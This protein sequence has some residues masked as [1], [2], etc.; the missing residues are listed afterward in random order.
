M[1]DID[2]ENLSKREEKN[3]K[4][5]KYDDGEIDDKVR[6][7]IKHVN[8][9]TIR[10]DDIKK[11]MYI[12]D[13]SRGIYLSDGGSYIKELCGK[14]R[15]TANKKFTDRFLDNLQNKTQ[16]IDTDFVPPKHLVNL[17]NGVFNVENG[18]LLPHNSKYYFQTILDIEYEENATCPIWEKALHGMIPDQK[19]YE[20][21]QKWF[22]YQFTKGSR[23]QIAHGYFGVAG[24]GKSTILMILR[25]L[26]GHQ[27]VTSFQIQEFANPNMYALARL[28]GKYANIT[29][30]MST[31]KMRDISSFKSL[32]SGEPLEGRNPHKPSVTFVNEAKFTWGCNKLPYVSDEVLE[33]EEFQRRIMLTKIVKGHKKEDIDKDIYKKFRDELSGI[34]NWASEGYRMYLDSGFEYDENVYNIWKENMSGN[35]IFTNEGNTEIIAIND[36]ND[37]NFNCRT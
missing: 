29:Y 7:F 32:T 28:Y 25:D 2:I 22:G 16:I 6:E 1:D 17:R 26:L 13:R 19:T 8:F 37:L 18:E 30:D 35:D 24:S 15:S 23:E 27:N 36:T 21:T 9:Y 34:F 31:M 12:Y 4:I 5:K 33:T 3:Y 10:S 20:R 11:R 14:S